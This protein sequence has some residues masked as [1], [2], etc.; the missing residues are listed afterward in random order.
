MLIL[1]ANNIKK[2]YRDRLILDFDNLKI[3]KE[4]RIGIV[5]LN[6]AGK[7]TLMNILTKRISPDEGFV[8]LYGTHSYI[9]Q[10]D[11]LDDD[12]TDLKV[13]SEFDVDYD[14][15][16]K[17]SGGEKT[18]LKIVKSL[19]KNSSILF[20]DE[21]TCNLDMKGI[22][23]IEEKLKDLD[24]PIVLI[25][26]DR[27]LLD[28]ICN[29]II[30]VEDG[31]IKEYKG[32]YS[33]YKEQKEMELKRKKDEYENYIREKKKLES[34]IQDKFEKTIS[35]KKTPSRMGNSEA[36]LHK[37]STTQIQG[38][39]HGARKA[40]ETR[41]EKLDKKERVIEPD[42]V[43][44]DI[45]SIGE[46][47]SKVVIRGKELSKSFGDK[48]LFKN[49]DIQIYNG[50]K[51]ALIGD[52]GTG[53]TTLIR[54]LLDG[55]DNIKVSKKAKIGYFSQNLN[56]L[57][58]NKT[59]LE[60]V[61]EDTIHS[62]TFVRTILGRLLFK[63]DDVNKMVS[64]LSGGERVKT[65]IAKIFLQDINIIILDEPTN[66][67][68]TDSIEAIEDVLNDYEG[69]LFFISHDRSFIEKI[70]H[71]VIVL[72]NKRLIEFNGTYKEY[73]ESKNKNDEDQDIKEQLL[74]LKNRLS[75]IT[76]RLSMPSVDD[77]VEELDREFKEVAREINLL[78]AKNK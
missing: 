66:F 53:K 7:T 3:Y 17:L 51:V 6:G 26:H 40:L 57:D 41:L 24:I 22:K 78:K 67:L 35:M 54:M 5:G 39:L 14:Y 76:G 1:E 75:E 70:A 77:D 64:I 36:R 62:Q 20:A 25:S 13:A 61:M 30:E 32:N 29:K 50:D 56:V 4:D 31:K 12:Y 15:S 19:S 42:K 65:A 10:L 73:I 33:D 47:H 48:V 71:K 27:S 52:N 23:M 74:V 44:I 55:H 11:N 8:K 72:E 45:P 16:N 37:R 28:N 43:K 46:L 9:P 21:P 38:K 60:N 68:D 18:R 63:N 69:T 2:Y 49:G 58:D 59:V 34:A